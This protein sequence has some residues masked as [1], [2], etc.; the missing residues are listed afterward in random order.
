MAGGGFQ[1]LMQTAVRMEGQCADMADSPT[2]LPDSTLMKQFAD[3]G[4]RVQGFVA[5]RVL[6]V[7]V[8]GVLKWCACPDHGSKRNLMML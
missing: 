6:G 8:E 5:G 2:L 7:W 1:V 4:C 3:G